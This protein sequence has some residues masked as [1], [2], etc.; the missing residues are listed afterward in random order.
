MPISEKERIKRDKLKYR[1]QV[2]KDKAKHKKQFSRSK[3][4]A[5]ADRVFSLYIRFVRDKDRWCITCGNTTRDMDNWHFQSRRFLNTR[6]S[7]MNCA[8]Q[9]SMVCNKWHSWE[10]VLFGRKID[11]MYGSGTAEAI[12]ILARKVSIITDDDILATIQKYYAILKEN[13]IDCQPK[14]QYCQ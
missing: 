2:R 14:K 1:E 3:L 5:E 4:I 10:Q 6:W 13:G 12:E 8:K 9:C 7:E 11:E